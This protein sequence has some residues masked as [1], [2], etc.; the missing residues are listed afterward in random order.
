MEYALFHRED[1]EFCEELA[2]SQLDAHEKERYQA[3]GLAFLIPRSLLKQ[4]IAKRLVISP[5]EVRFSYNEQGKP[6]L[7]EH[8]HLHFNMAHTGD[9]IAIA[10]DTQPI[11]IDIE[12]MKT[13]KF[14][15]IAKRVMPEES[16]R[17]FLERGATM[18]EFYM[19]WCACEALIKQAGS[20]IWLAD[21]FP[22]H[23]EDGR[24]ILPEGSP[25]SLS[26]EIFTAA[27]GIMGAIAQ[28]K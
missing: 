2:V 28:H 5:A 8:T 23:I 14:D 19:Y 1:C 22:F 13:R 18:E 10:F 7:P 11:G 24:I 4:Q 17:S 3:S 20:S 12:Q 25:S 16:Y 6:Y 15:R 26:V 9:H 27:S 21:Q